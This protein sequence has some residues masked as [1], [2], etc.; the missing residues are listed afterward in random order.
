MEQEIP[1]PACYFSP[2]SF[3]L[4][5]LWA[6]LSSSLLSAVFVWRGQ[7]QNNC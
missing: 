3:S 7:I 4:L 6:I 2:L 1:V 5:F